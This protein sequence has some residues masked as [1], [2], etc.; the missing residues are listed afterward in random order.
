MITQSFSLTIFCGDIKLDRSINHLKNICLM[1]GNLELLPW[2]WVYQGRK[3]CRQLA[4]FSWCLLDAGWFLLS[5]L[6]LLDTRDLPT[7]PDSDICFACGPWH[8]EWGMK[9]QFSARCCKERP[10]MCL[11][12]TFCSGRW[13]RRGNPGRWFRGSLSKDGLWSG[14]SVGRLRIGAMI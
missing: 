2:G 1:R 9:A 12:T 7:F 14:S 10:I 4:Y 6:A 5:Q 3:N 13:V 8:Q 11:D